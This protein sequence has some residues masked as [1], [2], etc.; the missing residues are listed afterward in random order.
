MPVSS[1]RLPLTRAADYRRIATETRA[2]A[3]TVTDANARKLMTD[4]ADTWDRLAAGLEQGKGEPP[5][6]E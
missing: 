6:E 2:K 5:Q 4:A 3:E 1:G